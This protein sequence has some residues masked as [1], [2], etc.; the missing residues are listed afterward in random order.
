MI[1]LLQVVNTDGQ[2]GAVALIADK[3]AIADSATPAATSTAQPGSLALC[4]D[5]NEGREHP[6][7]QKP[8]CRQ[9][10]AHRSTAIGAQI[11]PYCVEVFPKHGG[12]TTKNR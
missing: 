8:K 4:L 11:C 9:A 3:P 6:L 10:S 7:E 1:L 12:N 2:I 5:Q